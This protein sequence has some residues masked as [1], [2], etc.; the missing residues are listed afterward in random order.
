MDRVEAVVRDAEGALEQYRRRTQGSLGLKGLPLS[1]IRLA[2]ALA[3]C[4]K[5]IRRMQR[6]GY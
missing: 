2:M 1:E 4:V 6:H 5:M 3:R